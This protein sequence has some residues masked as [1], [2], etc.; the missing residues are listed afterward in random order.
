MRFRRTVREY[1]GFEG[2][3]EGAATTAAGDD[4]AT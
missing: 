2:G 4:G 3:G 1:F